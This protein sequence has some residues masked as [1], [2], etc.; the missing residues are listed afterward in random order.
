MDSTLYHPAPTTTPRPPPSSVR[1]LDVMCPTRSRRSS[2][3]LAVAGAFLVGSLAGIAGTRQF[4]GMVPTRVASL[5]FGAPW[6]LTTNLTATP[7]D[8]TCHV[9]GATCL[10]RGQGP[11]ERVNFDVGAHKLMVGGVFLGHHVVVMPQKLGGGVTVTDLA[12]GRSLGSLWY[13]N[14]GD[15][16]AIP[17]HII[18]F[19]SADPYAG[20]EFVNSVQGGL[21]THLYG[22][23]N[24]DPHPPAST[25]IYKL[26]YDGNTV[27]IMENVSA[28]TGLGLGVHT[29][30][31]PRDAESFAVSDGQKDVWALFDRRTTEVRAAFRYDWR[32]ASADLARNW[33]DGGVLTITRIYA[34]KDTGKFDML[35]TKGNKIDIELAP[36]AEGELEAGRIPGA[37]QAGTV[38][39]DGL[40]Y[41]PN[42]RWGVEIIRMLGGGVVHDLDA[43]DYAPITFVSFNGD[44]PDQAAVEEVEAGRV[45][46]VH[47]ERVGSPG[48]EVWMERDPPG[49]FG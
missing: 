25:N 29:T 9:G 38:A 16:G 18:A 39:A 12:T 42:G 21:N 46:R 32:G 19:P 8:W 43:D 49:A 28:T 27:Q 5:S 45:W 13:S 31:N 47:V 22:L 41:H 33:A 20:F 15:Y 35:G 34:D 7:A 17:H 26:R 6:P 48:H 36:M 40:V 14:Y 1:P 10:N 30:I 37:D 24:V 23:P 44:T 3:V 11:I 4:L 2:A